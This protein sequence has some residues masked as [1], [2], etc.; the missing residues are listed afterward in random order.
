MNLHDIVFNTKD[1]GAVNYVKARIAIEENFK[2]REEKRGAKLVVIEHLKG[3]IEHP[4]KAQ[5]ARGR[6]KLVVF[7]DNTKARF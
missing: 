5:L 1:S 6:T 4:T 7:H 2:N 3:N